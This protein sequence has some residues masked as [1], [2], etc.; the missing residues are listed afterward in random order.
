MRRRRCCW[1]WGITGRLLVAAPSNP[2]DWKRYVAVP[3]HSV[4][5]TGAKNTPGGSKAWEA[6]SKEGNFVIGK[7]REVAAGDHAGSEMLHYWSGLDVEVTQHFVRTPTAN[8]ADA[9]SINVGAEKGHSTGGSK[10]AGGDVLWQ[11]SKLRS[12]E[13]RDGTEVGG[14]VHGREKFPRSGGGVPI[15]SQR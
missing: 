8:Q 13:P 12:K 5:G 3:G 14:E 6:R 10:G 11:K 4:Q 15:G 9:V 1:C 7:K 2:W